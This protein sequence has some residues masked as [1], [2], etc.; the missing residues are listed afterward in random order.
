MLCFQ[1]CQ[2][3]RGTNFYWRACIII[4]A[5]KNVSIKRPDITKLEFL[6]ELVAFACGKNPFYMKIDLTFLNKD[7]IFTLPTKANISSS[8]VLQIGSS[9]V[10]VVPDTTTSEFDDNG[11]NRTVAFDSMGYRNVLVINTNVN[12]WANFFNNFICVSI[13]WSGNS[14]DFQAINQAVCTVLVRQ[15]RF[16]LVESIWYEGASVAWES[17]FPLLIRRLSFRKQQFSF[18][19]LRSF[20]RWN[21]SK[22]VMAQASYPT[23]RR[24]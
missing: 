13:E 20:S 18:S 24:A 1:F 12:D 4:F 16:H 9:F 15:S 19:C 17:D 21:P 11:R 3:F 22:I 10:K 7:F 5:K 23:T 6:L 8:Y 2:I 14:S